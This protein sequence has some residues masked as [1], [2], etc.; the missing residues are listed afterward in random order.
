VKKRR[1][2]RG[3]EEEEGRMKM[4]GGGKAKGPLMQRSKAEELEEK[5]RAASTAAWI[6]K[7]HTVTCFTSS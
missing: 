6:P 4:R 7:V 1:G 3:E 5:V 2:R